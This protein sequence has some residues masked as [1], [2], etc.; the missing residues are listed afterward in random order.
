MFLT[1]VVF[2]ILRRQKLVAKLVIGS[3]RFI[4]LTIVEFFI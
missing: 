1:I 4:I 2:T 3:L